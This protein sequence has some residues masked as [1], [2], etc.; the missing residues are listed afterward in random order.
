MQQPRP[1]LGSG[2]PC[3]PCGG[4]A[5]RGHCAGAGG[6]ES[7]G[8]GRRAGRAP[9]GLAHCARASRPARPLQEPA[10]PGQHPLLFAGAPS[11]P[12]CPAAISTGRRCRRRREAERSRARGRGPRERAARR[13]PPP[14]RR[15]SVSAA[16]TRRARSLAPGARGSGPPSSR[17]SC[18]RGRTPLD[19][20]A[21]G[22][23]PSLPRA[24]PPR[25]TGAPRRGR[26]ARPP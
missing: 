23:P 7:G 16:G 6:A 13:P 20:P 17:P 19:R 21:P 25:P 4:A 10:P 26:S 12:G 24:A 8:A 3:R 22:P 15:G 18:P 11:P 2:A 1:A 5:V 14:W 9:A